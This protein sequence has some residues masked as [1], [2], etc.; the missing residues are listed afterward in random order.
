MKLTKRDVFWVLSILIIALISFTF[1]YWISSLNRSLQMESSY[2]WELHRKIGSVDITCKNL[3]KTPPNNFLVLP[4][5]D[6]NTST[7]IASYDANKMLV[8]AFAIST[9]GEIAT[10]N[11]LLECN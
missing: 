6:D 7:I 5:E 9:S 11:W 3:R 8:H 10:D 4:F 1:G 2:P